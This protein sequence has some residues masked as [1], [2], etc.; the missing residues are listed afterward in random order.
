MDM[1]MDQPRSRAFLLLGISAPV[2]FDHRLM[3]ESNQL[4]IQIN[5][6]HVRYRCRIL[7]HI[8]YILHP[9]N[10]MIT[11]YKMLLSPESIK[12]DADMLSGTVR[13]IPHYINIIFVRQN[14]LIPVRYEC[15]IH[16]L[17]RFKRPST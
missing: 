7:P 11:Y 1:S 8:W 15:F 9:F 12:I 3:T 13:K 2:P 17:N 16:L 5:N 4:I 6:I 10:I 14:L